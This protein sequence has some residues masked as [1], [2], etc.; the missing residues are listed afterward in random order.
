MESTVPQIFA[1]VAALAAVATVTALVV[2]GRHNRRTEA[3]LTW[4]STLTVP[5]A[6]FATTGPAAEE[7]PAAEADTLQVRILRNQVRTLEQAL[8][9][10]QVLYSSGRGHEDLEAY[11]RRVHAVI[12]AMGGK[13][14][15]GAAAPEALARVSAAVDR[16]TVAETFVR[17]TL[18]AAPVATP[19]YLSPSY[20]GSE[21]ISPVRDTG[22]VAVLERPT[23]AVSPQP[24]APVQSPA[25]VGD[26]MPVDALDDQAFEL[27]Q[28]DSRPTSA[29][30]STQHEVVLP[31]PPMAQSE[32]NRRNRR[33]FRGRAA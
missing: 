28:G 31:V 11:R 20:L 22:A 33:W 6:T 3:A 26:M 9:Q 10:E 17:P 19:G 8:E 12:R 32:Q 16:L 2:R 4:I 23:T 30:V 24:A 21:H 27:S 18:T 5:P 13:L 15:A 7:E 29:E 1:V 25:P 14:D